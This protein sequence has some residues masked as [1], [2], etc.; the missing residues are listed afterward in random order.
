MKINLTKTPDQVIKEEAEAKKQQEAEI[1]ASMLE[2]QHKIQALHRVQTRNKW[3]IIFITSIIIIA[4]LVFG[5]YNTFI[6]KG[7]TQQDVANTVYSIYQQYPS[8]G[9]V[10]YL[11]DNTQTLFDKYIGFDKTLYESAKVD[12]NSI[13]INDIYKIDDLTAQIDF[14]ADVEVKAVD[15]QVQDLELMQQLINNGLGYKEKVEVEKTEDD[16]ATVMSQTLNTDGTSESFATSTDASPTDAEPDTATTDD[17]ITVDE[18]TSTE[19]KKYYLNEKGQIME[20]GDTTIMRYNF[21]IIVEYYANTDANGN[22]TTRGYK[23]VSELAL[24]ELNYDG[25]VTGDKLQEITPS[26]YLTF[27]EDSKADETTTNSAWTKVDK[28]LQDLYG[29]RDTTQ[30]FQN[31]YSFNTYGAKYVSLDEFTLYTESNSLGYNA[32][33]TYTIQTQQGFT[34]QINTYLYM[35]QSGAS[36]VIYSIL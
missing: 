28:T 25:N 29:G 13:Y 2:R 3:I 9:V 7:L 11:R 24:D 26:K 22:Y 20:V 30:D 21:T 1:Q 19:G 31:L 12:K 17:A 10:G 16:G 27:N 5:T 36:W 18:V 6:K 14:S 33:A 23:A 32:T 15:T 8:E 35:E 34:Y 4:L